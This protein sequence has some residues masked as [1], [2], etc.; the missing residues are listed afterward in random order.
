MFP[1]VTRVSACLPFKSPLRT[2]LSSE[3]EEYKGFAKPVWRWLGTAS[4][5]RECTLLS[6]LPLGS[7]E[8]LLEL[9]D[10]I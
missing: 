3:V 1:R 6:S 4:F 7:T 2:G 5:I 9:V 10:T 8:S